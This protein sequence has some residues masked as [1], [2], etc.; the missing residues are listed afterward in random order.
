M[1]LP[2][3]LISAFEDALEPLTAAVST[4]ALEGADSLD[5]SPEDLWRLSAYCETE[6]ERA[7]IEAA[8]IAASTGRSFTLPLRLEAL[9]RLDWAAR[10]AHD[11]PPIRIGRFFVHGAHLPAPAPGGIA[12][13]IDAGGAFG[14][15]DHASTRG[16]LVALDRLARRLTVR[17]AL[18]LGTGS[19][20]LAVAIAKTWRTR[21]VAADIDPQAVTAARSAVHANAVARSVDVCVSDGFRAPA[22]RT[23]RPYELICA[24]I[25]A[26]PLVRM[27]P[28]LAR[29]LAP[30]GW[31]VLSGLLAHQEPWVLGAY[32]QVR[33]RLARRV[34]LGEWTTLM[35]T[36]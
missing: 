6:V 3:R 19:G 1:T 22:V 18:D 32:R 24:N 11:F 23:K 35:L 14:S 17:R 26:G 2:R 31:A 21:V 29:H 20:I 12:V 33:L 34:A 5:E 30:R 27:A 36:R 28:E 4:Q 16:C 13:K 7:A 9:P 15:G 8:I 10:A 25:L